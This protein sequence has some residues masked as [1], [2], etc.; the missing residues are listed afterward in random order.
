M[1]AKSKDSLAAKAIQ[2]VYEFPGNLQ[3]GWEAEPSGDDKYVIYRRDGTTREV[4]IHTPVRTMKGDFMPIKDD[5][6]VLIIGEWSVLI[7]RG[8]NHNL[9]ARKLIK[10]NTYLVLDEKMTQLGR[11]TI[12]DKVEG[13]PVSL[14]SG[15]LIKVGENVIPVMPKKHDVT[16]MVMKTPKEDGLKA[17]INIIE[18]GNAMNRRDGARGV[19]IRPRAEGEPAQFVETYAGQRVVTAKFWLEKNEGKV[20]YSYR[21]A[22]SALKSNILTKQ[23]QESREV[24]IYAG[25]DP[26]DYHEYVEISQKL[27]REN[28]SWRKAGMAVSV[29]ADF[30][31]PIGNDKDFNREP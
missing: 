20:T 27:E 3:K 8:I 17:F 4:S 19:F 31:K 24:A 14:V 7:G 29:G 30:F 5:F 26:E 15:H 21:T 18:K 12:G 11:Y 13:S 22:E 23:L 1:V 16:L 25:I 28:S 10:D 9:H 6:G 2:M